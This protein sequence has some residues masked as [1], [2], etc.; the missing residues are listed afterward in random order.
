MSGNVDLHLLICGNE[1]PESIGTLQTD[2]GLCFDKE[3][4]LRALFNAYKIVTAGDLDTSGDGEPQA[5]M[6]AT[7]PLFYI[8][9]S[10]TTSLASDIEIRT[11]I[12]GELSVQGDDTGLFAQDVGHST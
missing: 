10:T 12:T 9:S 3:I 5:D 6:W 1:T 7:L 11:S 4:G 2:W 8:K